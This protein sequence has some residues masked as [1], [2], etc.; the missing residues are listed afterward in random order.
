MHLTKSS[1]LL[2]DLEVITVSI[3]DHS[4][5]VITM[6]RFSRPRGSSPNSLFQL[7]TKIE[8]LHPTIVKQ[9]RK[10]GQLN[11]ENKG[12]ISGGYN[13]EKYE[14]LS[15]VISTQ[16][17]S[18]HFMRNFLMQCH[19]DP[20]DIPN[21]TCSPH[22]KLLLHYYSLVLTWVLCFNSS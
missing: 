12:L 2:Y 5:W 18:K 1:L 20:S 9:A 7:Q 22:F 16:D 10:S 8:T 13:L 19:H 11:L 15:V 21:A 6:S 3:V 17:G 4:T 14:Q